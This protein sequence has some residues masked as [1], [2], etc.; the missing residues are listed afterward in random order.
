[1]KAG[2]IGEK[3]AAVTLKAWQALAVCRGKKS[4]HIVIEM[5]VGWAG[6]TEGFQKVFDRVVGID[7]KRQQ[8]VDTARLPEGVREGYQVEGRNSAGDGR[9]GRGQ[10]EGQDRPLR[11]HRLHRGV[12]G[13]GLQQLEGVRGR[14]L[15]REAEVRVG[16][17]G[18]RFCDQGGQAGE[19]EGPSP[20]VRAEE[21]CLVSPAIR[22][23][24]EGSTS[25][26]E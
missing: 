5:G 15:C 18:A 4:R 13:P 3:E 9:Q 25:G 20:P 12:P 11:V 14:V 8:G 1:M 2:W 7:R 24:A 21:P 10:G 23:A 26:R 6:A 17:G 19:G 16:T 22:Q